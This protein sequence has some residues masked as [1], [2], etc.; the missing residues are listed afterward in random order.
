ILDEFI[1]ETKAALPQEPRDLLMGIAA[2]RMEQDVPWPTTRRIWLARLDR[3]ADWF[4]EEEIR[5]RQEGAPLVIEEKRTLPL[6]DLDFTLTGKVDRI[7]RQNDGTMVVYD[8]KTGEAPTKPMIEHF[9]KQLLLEAAMIE[10]GAFEDCAG[11]SVSAVTYISL[12]S[13]PKT[14]VHR[15]EPGT[16]QAIWTD[17]AELIRAWSMPERGYTS[18]RA[19][20]LRTDARDYD[21]LA[22]FGEWD[23]SSEPGPEEV[24]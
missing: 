7:D 17:L 16:A 8:Y 2:R 11:A 12:G 1:R 20:N 3:V 18:R 14:T 13:K 10:Q 19:M 15:L 21:H 5:R 24:G 9:D 6:G 22:R 23:E 4:I